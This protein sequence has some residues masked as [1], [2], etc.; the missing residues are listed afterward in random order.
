MKRHFYRAAFAFLIAY[1]VLVLIALSTSAEWANGARALLNRFSVLF[2]GLPILCLDYF[3]NVRAG[4][5]DCLHAAAE[6][7]EFLQAID[8]GIFHRGEELLL[9]DA[10]SEPKAELTGPIQVE[11]TYLFA[12]PALWERLKPEQVAT[13]VQLFQSIQAH[14]LPGEAGN[15]IRFRM[16]RR[17]LRLKMKTSAYRRATLYCAPGNAD[18]CTA[19]YLYGQLFG[20][21]YY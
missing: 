9:L 3:A 2:L 11:G 4:K 19:P 16:G 21:W 7:K 14:S 10:S 18:A 13:F 20:N 12:T 8:A 6:Q 5:R 15:A 17:W 1:F